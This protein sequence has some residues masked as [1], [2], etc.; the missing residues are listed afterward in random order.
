MKDDKAFHTFLKLIEEQTDHQPMII[1][2]STGHY[3]LP[4]TRFLEDHHYL[5]EVVNPMLAYQPR[6]LIEC[7]ARFRQRQ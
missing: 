5:F 3:H 2:E 7:N 6:I 4:V 1:L